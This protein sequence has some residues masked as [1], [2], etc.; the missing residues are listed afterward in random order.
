[1]D[2]AQLERIPVRMQKFVDA[3]TAAG[4]VTLAAVKGKVV[5]LS[6]VGYQ[7]LET[8]TP[9]RTD[10]IFEVMSLTK[11]VTA[12]S[13][14]T[15]VDEGKISLVDPVEDYVP[16]FKGQL[17]ATLPERQGACRSGAGF[18][19]RGPS[20]DISGVLT[21]VE[22]NRFDIGM[23]RK[24]ADELHAAITSISDDADWGAHGYLCVSMYKHTTDCRTGRQPSKVMGTGGKILRIAA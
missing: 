11:A 17:D 10:T 3:G 5:P 15:L 7:D 23:A 20:P 2:P 22:E 12:A 1:M 9:M 18:L 16:E 8:K 13:I 24:D 4:F 19:R 21:M 6:A 14:L